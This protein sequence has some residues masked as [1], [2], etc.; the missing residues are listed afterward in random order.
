MRKITILLLILLLTACN[1]SRPNPDPST[2]P[3]PDPAITAISETPAPGDNY[4]QCAWAWNTQSLPDV[5]AKVQSALEAAGL[6]GTTVNAEA[7][8]EDC[9]TGT[10]QVDRFA[11]METD[12]RISVKVPNLTEPAA[13]G[14]LLE[15]ILVVLDAF[16]PGV[17][18]G[19][20]AGYIG[21]TFQA[22]SDEL[23]LWFMVSDGKA[24]RALGLHGA[25][26]LDKLQ[27]K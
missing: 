21:V 7:F 12:F 27:N 4:T 10:G 3:G 25:A 6:T 17:V 14:D 16:P 19:P 1:L 13:L 15:Q 24:A 2:G 22:G 20:N 5:S 23:R 26:L 9:I 8:G 18:P 11:V